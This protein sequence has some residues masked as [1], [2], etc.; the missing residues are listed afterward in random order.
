MLSQVGWT[1]LHAN[2]LERPQVPYTASKARARMQ[3]GKP[4]NFGIRGLPLQFEGCFSFVSARLRAL[5][6]LVPSDASARRRQDTVTETRSSRST[7]EVTPL[8]GG[9]VAE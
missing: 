3:A 1:T 5:G 4:S 9:R 6:G 2:T 7:A 8:V